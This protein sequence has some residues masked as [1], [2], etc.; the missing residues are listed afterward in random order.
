[1]ANSNFAPAAPSLYD[2]APIA[3]PFTE[4]DPFGQVQQSPGAYYLEPTPSYYDAQQTR[5]GMSHDGQPATSGTNLDTFGYPTQN[6]E[7]FSQD[8]NVR[9]SLTL[10]REKGEGLH[11][12]LNLGSKAL[13]VAMKVKNVVGTRSS[14]LNSLPNIPQGTSLE[15]VY[16]TVSQDISAGFANRNQY[17][18]QVANY[19]GDAAMESAK[20]I[21]SDVGQF[22][23]DRY[24]LQRD[25]EARFGITVA[26]KRRFAKGVIK[27]GL[28]PTSEALALGRGAANIGR[29]SAIHEGRKHVAAVRSNARGMAHTYTRSG[30]F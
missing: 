14:R 26:N 24:G 19:V 17:D 10:D 12:V 21:A 22:A 30:I 20:N 16:N 8:Y 7:S 15:N 6:T 2:Q 27:A 13:D 1:M 28:N 29:K 23:M 18:Q 11:R 25:R 9:D 4:Q 5:F 3:N